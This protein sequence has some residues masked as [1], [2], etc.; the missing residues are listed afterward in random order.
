MAKMFMRLGL[1]CVLLV[2]GVNVHAEKSALDL[3]YDFTAGW[4]F[5]DDID[6]EPG[7]VIDQSFVFTKMLTYHLGFIYVDDVE[8]LLNGTNSTP[9]IEIDGPYI[10]ASKAFDL[11]FFDFSLGGGIMKA[12]IEAFL[13][14]RKTARDREYS[15]FLQAQAEYSLNDK[16]SLL[17]SWKYFDELSGGRFHMAQLGLRLSL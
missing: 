7:Y 9:R 12:E 17:G 6:Y 14:G 13:F 4:A 2:L 15:P 16:L 11:R 1:A 5:V 3:K 10:A 8:P